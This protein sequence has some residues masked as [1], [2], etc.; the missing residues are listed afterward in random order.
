MRLSEYTTW[1][2]AKSERVLAISVIDTAIAL[3]DESEHHGGTAAFINGGGPSLSGCRFGETVSAIVAGLNEG[4][5][6]RLLESLRPVG[7]VRRS[8]LQSSKW[9][10]ARAGGPLF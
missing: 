7:V 4:G 5:S 3:E 2:R 8:E 9:L 6:E 1:E 10:T